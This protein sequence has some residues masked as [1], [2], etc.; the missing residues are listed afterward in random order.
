MK[1]TLE[2]LIAFLC[3]GDKNNN[4]VR[5]LVTVEALMEWCNE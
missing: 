2:E 1:Y 3:D 5:E 4:H